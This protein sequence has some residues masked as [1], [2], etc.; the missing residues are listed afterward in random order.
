YYAYNPNGTEQWNQ[1]VTNPSTDTVPDDG[2]QASPSTGQPNGASFVNAG[3]LGQ[4]TYALNAGNGYPEAGWPRF[5]ADSVFSTAAVG[6][7]YGTGSDDL[8]VGGASTAGE[9]Y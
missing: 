6:D 1:V 5:T 7:L 2:V 3:A 9:A 4:E 8:V